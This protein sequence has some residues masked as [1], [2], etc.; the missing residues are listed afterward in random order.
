MDSVFF[1]PGPFLQEENNLD[2]LLFS[3]LFFVER[4]ALYSRSFDDRKQFPGTLYC[5]PHLLFYPLLRFP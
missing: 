5:S 2:G 4:D 3:P 1:L